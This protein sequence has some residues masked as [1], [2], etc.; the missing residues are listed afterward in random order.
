MTTARLV[1]YL[2]HRG[3][4]LSAMV[5]ATGLPVAVLTADEALPE[6]V[7]RAGELLGLT[8]AG[9]ED[10]ICAWEQAQ[11]TA[12]VATEAAE[13]DRLMRLDNAKQQAIAAT[14]QA[15]AEAVTEASIASTITAMF[16][17]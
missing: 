15:A 5:A 11:V 10:R 3:F 13:A 12:R 14:Q 9:V 6:T 2:Q 7:R 8:S 4:S 17:A 1:A 16:T